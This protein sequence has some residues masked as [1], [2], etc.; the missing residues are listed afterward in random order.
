MKPTVPKARKGVLHILDAAGYSLAGARRLLRETAARLELFGWVLGVVLLLLKGSG[1]WS[2]LTFSGL[3]G[4][5]LIVEALNTALEEVVDHLSPE[6][7]VMAKN[8]KDL[9]SFAVAV[10]LVLATGY[11]GLALFS[12]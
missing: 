9:G 4:L 3:C 11:L 5:V 12:H 8:A 10:S 2:L 6:W 1:A 7:S